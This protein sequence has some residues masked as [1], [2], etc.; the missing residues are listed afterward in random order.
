LFGVKTPM[1]TAL[2]LALC[3]AHTSVHAPEPVA[4]PDALKQSDVRVVLQAN[5]THFVATNT[6]FDI[7]VLVF[8]SEELG[9]LSTLRLAPGGTV[10]FGHAGDDEADVWVE[11][12]CISPTR[13]D[14][15]AHQ[16]SDIIDEGGALWIVQNNAT[17]ESYCGSKNDQEDGVRRTEPTGDLVLHVPGGPGPRPKGDTPPVIGGG[18]LPVV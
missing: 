15:G 6:S 9:V 2:T 14:S 3:A 16:V 1:L 12:V 8:G 17:L 10:T 11:V 13:I 4:T 7:A 18:P 5:E